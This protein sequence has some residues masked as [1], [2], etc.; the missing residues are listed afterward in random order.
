MDK[1]IKVDPFEWLALKQLEYERDWLKAGGDEDAVELFHSGQ[2]LNDEEY[3]ELYNPRRALKFFKLSAEL[4]YAPAMDEYACLISSDEEYVEQDIEKAIV[5]LSKSIELGFLPSYSSLAG[6]YEESQGVDSD[7]QK[8]ADLYSVCAK[9][10]D[11]VSQY[12]LARILDQELGK[13]KDAEY[14]YSQ[15]MVGSL[16]AAALDLGLMYYWG[17]GEGTSLMP[18]SEPLAIDYFRAFSCFVSAY[19][20]MDKGHK[21]LGDCYLYGHGVIA[22]TQM[23]I[24]FYEE[25]AAHGDSW[26]YECLG[27]IYGE[28]KYVPIDIAK[29]IEYYTKGAE[30]ENDECM[31]VLGYFY[32]SGQMEPETQVYSE[33]IDPE[34]SL[35]W[36]NLGAELGNED[37]I[38]KIE[39][40]KKGNWLK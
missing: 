32:Y 36:F 5:L 29:A 7:I 19:N 11:P 14:W 10:N 27:E 12:F 38:Y 9:E 31:S 4:G 2:S 33:Y 34:K 40:Y 21:Q 23:A 16:Y 26:G 35:Y 28:G 8:A 3:Q 30:L 13:S 6:I 37:C 25:A 24:K 17:R 1:K 22:D 15:A 39:Q 18:N 20:N